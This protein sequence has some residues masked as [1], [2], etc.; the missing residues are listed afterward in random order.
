MVGVQ[1]LDLG[2][3]EIPVDSSSGYITFPAN[4]CH[5]TESKTELMEKVFPNIAQNYKNIHMA[6]CILHVPVLENHEHY[7]FSHQKTRL[8]MLFIKKR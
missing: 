5:F 4:F 7:L 3:G 1:L 6:N 8:K 2:N